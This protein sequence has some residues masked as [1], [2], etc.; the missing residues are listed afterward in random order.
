MKH[1]SIFSMLLAAFLLLSCSPT[2]SE[3]ILDHRYVYSG[4]SLDISGETSNA[5]AST[6]HPDGTM[7]YV[8]G[9]STE[10]VVSYSVEFPW[11]LNR[12]SLK[13]SYDLSVELTSGSVAHGLFIRDDGQKMWVFNR[14]EM[15]GYELE[16][17]WDVASATGGYR[18]DFSEHVQ[19]GHDVD[20]SEDGTRLFIDDR[21][22]R[23][24]HQYKLGEAWDITTANWVYS[25]DISAHERQVRGIEIVKDGSVMLLLDTSRRELQQYN[26]SEPYDVSTATFHSRFDL[27]R[28]TTDPR[29]LSISRDLTRFYITGRDRGRIYQYVRVE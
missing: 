24:V 19:R 27:S 22:A 20:F 8:T 17:P 10:N 23:A 21:S 25:L 4:V 14:T 1:Q 13:S 28:Q 11:E 26:L 18:V 2:K 29:G 3:L 9:R 16:S 12:A 15:W 5:R 7:I 6:W